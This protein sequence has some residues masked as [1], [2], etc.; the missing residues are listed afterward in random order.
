MLFIILSSAPV[1]IVSDF[2]DRFEGSVKIKG[3]QREM[4]VDDKAIPTIPFHLEKE[5]EI[6][7]IHYT[8]LLVQKV[9]K[10]T[11]RNLNIDRHVKVLKLQNLQTISDFNTE[12]KHIFCQ[13]LNGL[14]IYLMCNIRALYVYIVRIL[15]EYWKIVIKW[16]LIYFD[17]ISILFQNIT[18]NR[19]EYLN[20]LHMVII[21][22]I[23]KIFA[24]NPKWS[25]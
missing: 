14:S 4:Q 10:R 19:W 24:M 23:R 9:I 25:S 8:I 7:N 17:S 1:D 3:L 11:V 6:L 13:Q 20:I 2:A 5:G 18:F 21:E 22:K 16:T 12:E 15:R